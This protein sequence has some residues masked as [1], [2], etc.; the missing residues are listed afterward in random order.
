M[1]TDNKDLDMKAFVEGHDSKP[2]C[3]HILLYATLVHAQAC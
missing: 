3:E 1:E 2:C